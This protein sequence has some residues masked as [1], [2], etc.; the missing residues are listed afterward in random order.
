MAKE[1]G[2]GW[3]SLW[4]KAFARKGSTVIQAGRDVITGNVFFG[5]FTRLKDPWRDPQV[6]FER[7]QLENFAGREWLLGQID[8]Y[9]AGHTHGYVIVEA[10]AGL[11][12]STLAAWLARSRG[13]PCHFTWGDHGNLAA[14]AL[15]NLAAQ[16][17]A[18]YQLEEFAPH[19]LLPEESR[20]P[21]WFARVLRAAVQKA[22]A[23]GQSVVL[24]VDG[25]DVAEEIQGSLPLG[26][27]AVL[28]PG[29]FIVATCRTGTS[30]R[31][32]REPYKI[33]PISAVSAE[34]LRDLNIFLGARLQKDTELAQRL[35]DAFATLD[36]AA[37]R[38]LRRCGGVWIYLRYVLSELQS[39]QRKPQDI[40][41]LPADL[42]GY[43]AES[44]LTD[45]GDADW[46]QLKLPLL[47]TLAVASEP[48]SVD[49]LTR[50]SG[51]PDRHL[52]SVQCGNRLRPFLTA[53]GIDDSGEKPL[54]YGIYHASL[55]EF[56]T[57]QVPVTLPG[58]SASIRDDLV[59]GADDA[60]S[61]IADHY[62]TM[63]GGLPDGLPVIASNPSAA[64]EDAGYA[65]RH[66]A[67]HLDQ[68]GRVGDL[69][70]LVNCECPVAVRGGVWYAAHH[71]AGTLGGYRADLDL[72]RRRAAAQ[73]DHDLDSGR[74][75]PGFATEL[76]CL[77]IDS[78]V[79]TL[80]TNVPPQLIARLVDSG[81]W[82]PAQ[83][84]FYARQPSD[85]SERAAALAI[86]VSHL[87]AEDQPI[88]MKEA[89]ATASQVVGAYLRARTFAALL[90]TLPAAP[91]DQLVD[92]AMRATVA[93]TGD[94]DRCHM[95]E[96]LVGYLTGPRV[97]Q[98]LSLSRSIS[99]ET[100]RVR[101][102]VALA[103]AVPPELL[104]AMLGDVRALTDPRLRSRL[105]VALAPCAPALLAEL[106]EAARA[107]TTQAD[108]ARALVAVACQLA[109]PGSEL[110]AEACA[111]GYATP[112][113]ADRAWLLTSLAAQCAARQREELLS[114]ALSTARELP[115]EADRVGAL[116][117]AAHY[118]SGEHRRAVLREALDRS[119][120][121]PADS[122]RA[123]CLGY[124]ASQLPKAQ[125]AEAIPAVLAIQSERDRALIFE[126]YAP[127]FGRFTE[128]ALEAV[129]G[130]RDEIQRGRC[131]RA[132]APYLPPE[133]FEEA[134]AATDGVSN[135][136]ERSL[137]VASLAVKIPSRLLGQALALVQS[138]TTESG[139]A[140][141]LR[142]VAVRQAE[143]SRAQLLQEALITA[144]RATDNMARAQSLGEIAASM[145]A[146]SQDTV[147]GE[148]VSAA[149]SHEYE[150]RRIYALDYLIPLHQPDRRRQVL[151]QAFAV[152]RVLS[153][154]V[155]K[156]W[157]LAALARHL[158]E[159]ERAAP[160]A[161]S[162]EVIHAMPP[163]REQLQALGQVALAYPGIERVRV[164]KELIV[165]AEAATDGL[166]PGAIIARL[167]RVM[168][169]K[170]KLRL[171]EVIR[172][173]SYEDTPL[174]LP[175][176]VVRRIP[177][178]II[179]GVLDTIS[180][181]PVGLHKAHALG[182]GAL[183][184]PEKYR[185]RSVVIALN[186]E[187]KVVARRA[188]MTQAQSLWAAGITR[189]EIEVVRQSITGLELDEYLGVLDSTFPIIAR[190]AGPQALDDCLEA[191]RTVQRWW[192]EP[193]APF[194][195]TP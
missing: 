38:L 41:S 81:D 55:H 59:R 58:V 182:T 108:R 46:G 121:C 12:K 35:A 47:S 5:S 187:Q 45:H 100:S 20:K 166:T 86:L 107:I 145:D 115:E 87:P 195:A 8:G 126:A 174:V 117:A 124:L 178:I 185:M 112:D 146:A 16:L 172:R 184:T 148:A 6:E 83:G 104:P 171:L 164:L 88:V 170:A 161:E 119:L 39:G 85:H 68:A 94:A 17:I 114:A 116:A 102:L 165:R 50:L 10:D 77:M 11:G 105:I 34:N 73:T 65:L 82:L 37:D 72:V 193:A 180:D 51:L 133:L 160:L 169:T 136:D 168:P 120:N 25:L 26:L 89:V 56:L 150:F 57:G 80:T 75:A 151:D 175:K 155:Y 78:A 66:L 152:A 19:G 122:G 135:A 138:M 140:R 143:P 159:S 60:Q 84:L 106:A 24:V 1:K 27:P 92:E 71:R 29:A 183:H 157:W 147:L 95:L 36:A 97:A 188:L 101:A 96:S 153:D 179:G 131:L 13:W 99:E 141:F 132:L 15:S 61:R 129:V 30:L 158:P 113:L 3:S 154:P 137:V 33:F 93:I 128:S 74:L 67:E 21:A 186:A 23:A 7:V 31:A 28:P 156:A 173:A 44:L 9:L 139:S 149:N 98:A 191:F 111:A 76:R 192:A 64:Q 189:A 43:Y 127:V 162:L 14:I 142:G 123:D 163:G 125:L 18:Q 91:Q 22:K 103:P 63:F 2:I 40:D 52:V 190:A 53:I 144:R 176:R 194:T 134:L 69:T 54:R 109:E 110:M 118:L 181:H 62:L 48:L 42:S 177:G 167:A 130:V 70:A 49:T 32:L 4:Q 79:R 90:A